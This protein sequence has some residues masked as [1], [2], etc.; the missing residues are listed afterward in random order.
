[1]YRKEFIMHRHVT[2]P[3]ITPLDFPDADAVFNCGQTMFNGKTLLLLSVCPREGRPCMHIATS[4]DGVKFDIEPEPF[5]T[6]LTDGP[7][8]CLDEWAIDPRITRIDDTY[9]I[10]RPAYSCSALLEKTTDWKTRETIDCI[11]LPGNRVPCLFPE[12]ID[13]RYFIINRMSFGAN[14]ELWISSSSDLVDWGRHR[15]IQ[16]TG[17]P[18][19]V[20]WANLKIG[21]TPPVKTPDGWLVIIHGVI[22]YAGGSRYSLG[23]IMLDLKNPSRMIGKSSGWILTPDEPYEFMGNCQNTIF[24]CGCIAEPE[25]DLIRIYYGAADTCIGLASGKLSELIADCMKNR[26]P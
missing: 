13:G 26:I 9:Y 14:S 6:P 16:G 24:S 7:L 4:S 22:P 5:I 10:V 15:L 8:A 2:N 18:Y 3:I 12:K 20:V 19:S 23:A 21:P 11:A 17:T 25:K 1:M